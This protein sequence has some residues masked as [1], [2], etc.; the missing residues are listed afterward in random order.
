MNGFG[1]T[2]PLPAGRKVH[3]F[4]PLLL[5][6]DNPLPYIKSN[7]HQPFPRT[8]IVAEEK[9]V[10]VPVRELTRLRSPSVIAPKMSRE[11]E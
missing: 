3:I 2:P 1:E 7:N 10:L 4:Q 6:T 8:P 5:T 9:G 11:A